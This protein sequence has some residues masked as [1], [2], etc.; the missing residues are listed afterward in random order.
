[1]TMFGLKEAEVATLVRA[2]AGEELDWEAIRDRFARAT[3]T[4]IA[5]PGDRTAGLVVDAFGAAAAL[6]AVVE[7]WSAERWSAA[8]KE[9]GADE[10]PGTELQQAMTTF[11]ARTSSCASMCRSRRARRM[12]IRT[13]GN[14]SC[15]T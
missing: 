3:W 11:A 6:D 10:I 8:A 12:S 15:S 9:A 4:G 13:C 5:E 14:A 1:M 7:R 2:V